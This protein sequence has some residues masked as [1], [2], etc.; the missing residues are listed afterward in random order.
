[1]KFVIYYHDGCEILDSWKNHDESH[2]S[3][4]PEDL[5]DS[6]FVACGKFDNDMGIINLYE[7]TSLSMLKL[8][9]LQLLELMVQCGQTSLTIGDTNGKEVH[10]LYDRE[11]V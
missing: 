2:R 3:H 5:K 1:M 4:L 6:E 7:Y 9:A 8:E 10:N 11:R